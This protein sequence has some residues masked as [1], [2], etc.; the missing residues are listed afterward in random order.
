MCQKNRKRK[1][2][3]STK[4]QKTLPPPA[5]YYLS[6]LKIY[7]RFKTVHLL[8][9]MYRTIWVQFYNQKTTTQNDPSM[10]NYF[11]VVYQKLIGG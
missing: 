7:C 2:E 10:T 3:K 1:Y 6:S 11:Q 9:T 4:N 5:P 8:K